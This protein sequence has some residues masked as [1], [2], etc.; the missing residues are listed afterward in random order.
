MWANARKESLRKHIAIE[1]L[2]LGKSGARRNKDAK[3]NTGAASNVS[4]AGDTPRKGI[5]ART[6]CSASSA[7]SSRL[8]CTP[9]TYNFIDRWDDLDTNKDGVWSLD[10]ARIDEANLGCRL[11]IPAEDIFQSNCRGIV[12][13]V[14]DTV[15]HRHINYSYTVPLSI[16]EYQAVPKSYFDWWVGIVVL[17]VEFSRDRCSE[18][19]ANGVFDGAIDSGERWTVGGVH[20]LD[21]A[22]DFCERMLQS[23]GICE[24]ALP[25]FY[26]T[27][28]ARLAEKCGTPVFKQGTRYVNPGDPRDALDTV[29]VSYT[30]VS[31]YEVYSSQHFRIFLWMI[32][33]IWYITLLEEFRDVLKNVDF[34]YRF[35]EH[36]SRSNSFSD[37][38][39]VV[40]PRSG[41]R[42]MLNSIVV[43]RGTGTNELKATLGDNDEDILE[44]DSMAWPHW[45]LCATIC[46][47]RVALL[48]YL[49]HVGTVFLLTDQ[50]YVNLLLLSVTLAFIIDLPAVLYMTL[51]PDRA[52]NALVGA[53]TI[54]YRTGMST[55]WIT[56]LFASKAIWG[57]FILPA[58]T[59]W[60]VNSNYEEN[61]APVLESLK[62][63]CL[64]EGPNCE[65]SDRFTRE[66][67]NTY[68]AHIHLMFSTNPGS[69]L[70]TG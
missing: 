30:Q 32:L 12:R 58:V 19:V 35:H 36:I 61:I 11:G 31:K 5:D 63:A 10:E 47:A 43:M 1:F 22:L 46:L 21:S 69:Y 29:D 50:G 57:I 18:L 60:A 59:Y 66:R 34:V 51:M 39:Q 2:A 45:F 67:W 13:S 70:K 68:W 53:H 9:N 38:N 33:L 65:V 8:L 52:K 55:N 3:D 24:D 54:A 48:C 64:Q 15:Q 42:M 49:F 14:R 17:C 44:V 26:L 28:R 20:N 25:G 7:N 41:R 23:G 16:S 4:D 40:S 56:S 6:I 27:H 62:C 37:E